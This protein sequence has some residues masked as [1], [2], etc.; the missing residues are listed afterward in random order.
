MLKMN[1]LR[2]SYPEILFLN[3]TIS[4]TYESSKIKTEILV[5]HFI[6]YK[7]ILVRGISTVKSV[8]CTNQ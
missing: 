2:E 7:L 6:L 4:I 5:S 8:P 1:A 3:L